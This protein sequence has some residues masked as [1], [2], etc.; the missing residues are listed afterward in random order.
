MFRIDRSSNSIKRLERASF[1][2]LSFSERNHLQ[3]WIADSP[4]CLGEDLLIIQKEFD[5]FD[6]TKER[7]DLLALDKQG[8]LV[9]IEN[10]LD[11]TGRD[12]VWQALKYASYCSTLKTGQIAEIFGSYLGTSKS[13]AEAAIQE[14][15]GEENIDEIVLNKGNEQRIF[16]IAAKFRKEVTATSLWLLAHGIDIRC[17]RVSPFLLEGEILLNF[18]QIIPP[19]EAADYMIGISE[20]DA[21]VSETEKTERRRHQLRREFWT[22]CLERF[23]KSEVGLYNNISPHDD[24]WMS[25]GS[26]VSACPYNLIFSKKE[27]RLELVFS[28][29]EKADNKALFDWLFARR[30]EIE[31]AFGHELIWRRL[32]DKISSRIEFQHDFDGFNRDQWP[33]MIDWLVQNMKNFHKILDPQ[34]KLAAK[35]VLGRASKVE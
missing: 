6:D 20:K 17:F 32:D 3:E 16:L 28:R 34:F 24:H 25:A 15:L 31:R 7:L 1:S 5:G 9:V 19:P 12:V 22:L 23:R 26:G 10:K 21:E 4:E 2:Q 8:R 29:A 14:F 13:E 30:E 35:T 27:A 11:D 33:D 18:E